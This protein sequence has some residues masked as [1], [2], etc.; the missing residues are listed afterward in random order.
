MS[1]NG[2]DDGSCWA[3]VYRIPLK[4]FDRRKCIVEEKG[5]RRGGGGGGGGDREEL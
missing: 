3:S 1:C 2:R 4:T 5:R